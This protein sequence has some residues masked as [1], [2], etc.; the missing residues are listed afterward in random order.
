M[1]RPNLSR[2][3]R[4]ANIRLSSSV[5][6][7]G[8]ELA[9]SIP[10]GTR[11]SKAI[12]RV[13]SNLEEIDGNKV[14]LGKDISQRVIEDIEYGIE[15][16]NKSG[17]E[18]MKENTVREMELLMNSIERLQSNQYA[19]DYARDTDVLVE[20][21][22]NF[23]QNLKTPTRLNLTYQS[24][25]G[26]SLKEFNRLSPEEQ[27][28]ITKA[29][30]DNEQ[31]YINSARAIS[32]QKGHKTSKFIQM[33][34]AID[35]F[36]TRERSKKELKAKIKAGEFSQATE[37]QR[38]YVDSELHLDP[39]TETVDTSIPSIYKAESIR[40]AKGKEWDTTS[41]I[42]RAV[43]YSLFLAIMGLISSI[44]YQDYHRQ[45][46]DGGFQGV[47]VNNKRVL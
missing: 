40:D 34:Q 6:E 36:R 25:Y 38:E 7:Q 14:R 9:V 21:Q 43:Y 3:W 12:P 4:I 27:K 33:K 44:L 28:N 24:F 26:M 23:T 35:S 11:L 16:I 39:P 10:K 41:T 37:L 29:F 8:A 13:L 5:S 15:K 19:V 18:A 20:R 42:R 1:L 17:S 32:L 47:Y 45:N 31:E 46:D 30:L 22:R 2:R